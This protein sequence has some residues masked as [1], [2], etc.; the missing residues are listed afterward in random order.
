MSRAFLLRFFV[1]MWMLT[2]GFL[3]SSPL[4]RPDLN[5]VTAI[6]F[7][8]LAFFGS[9]ATVLM[10]WLAIIAVDI[11]YDEEENIM[12]DCPAA[13]AIYSLSFF[14]NLAFGVIR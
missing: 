11:L 2:A 9:V 6:V 3:I 14:F 5:L 13:L 1:M 7:A 4:N 12:L 8:V 10:G